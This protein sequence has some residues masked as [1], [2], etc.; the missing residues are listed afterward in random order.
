MSHISAVMHVYMLIQ[1]LASAHALSL[2]L[3][4]SLSVSLYL[5]ESSQN[6]FEVSLSTVPHFWL[7]LK[8]CAIIWATHKQTHTHARGRDVS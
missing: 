4:L 6:W 7:L 1:R 3:S 5:S 8:Q 2:S